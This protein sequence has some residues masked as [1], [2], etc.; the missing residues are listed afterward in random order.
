MI[1]SAFI[2]T[3]VLVYAYDAFSP[4]KQVRAGEVLTLLAQA[5][6]GCLSCQVLSEFVAVVTKKI[7][8]PLGIAD[9]H[10]RVANFLRVWRVLDLTGPIVLEACRGVREHRLNYWDALIWASARLNQIPLILSEDFRDNEVL[11]G[12]R[13]LNPFRDEFDLT[14]L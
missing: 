12:V 4:A 14:D 7:P 11:E 10:E 6:T 13:F 2:D 3:N 9:A 8:A 5:G 1:A